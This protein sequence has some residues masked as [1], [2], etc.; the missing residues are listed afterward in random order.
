MR[1]YTVHE[2]LDPPA[3]R[4][5]RAEKLV[6]VADGFDSWA[7]AFPPFAL[8]GYKLYWA[9]AAYVLAIVVIVALLSAVGANPAFYG[10][11]ILALHSLIGYEMGEI[12]RVSLDQQ[13]WSM[14]GPVSGR[15]LAE[16]E[17][18]FLD[19][20]LPGQPMITGLR[21]P[22]SPAP[23]GADLPGL[24]TAQIPPASGWRGRL[25]W[26]RSAKA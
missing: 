5:D 22:S 8:L 26:R 18:R 20:W 11:L 19:Q 1:Y 3:D 13:G 25:P 15:T 24:G 9:F 16:C 6:F 2:P 7:A 17:R 21:P 23:S 10:L 4:V 14:I 12:R